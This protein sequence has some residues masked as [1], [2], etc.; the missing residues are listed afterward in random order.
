LHEK[1]KAFV[2]SK[3]DLLTVHLYLLK[4][5]I[6]G[7]HEKEKQIA[8]TNPKPS[9]AVKIKTVKKDDKKAPASTP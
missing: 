3:A 4:T 8:N 2:R 6:K 9:T 1:Y 7:K 5:Q